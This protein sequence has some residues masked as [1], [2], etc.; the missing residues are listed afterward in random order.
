MDNK[1]L[2][3][4]VAAILAATIFITIKLKSIMKTL[5]DILIE[6]QEE[7]TLTG[8]L[9][10]LLNGIKKRLE[11]ALSG[12]TLPP[13]AQAKVDQVFVD[14]EANKQQIVDALNA[15][16]ETTTDT[17]TEATSEE[18]TDTTTESV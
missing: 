11:D 17:T 10:T 5:D 18:T 4:T 16:T 12:T 7:R 15:N 13:A 3:I 8:S 14:L 6:V 2:L 1:N 9:I